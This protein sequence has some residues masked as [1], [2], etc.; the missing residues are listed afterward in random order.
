MVFLPIFDQSLLRL[1]EELPGGRGEPGY[2]GLQEGLLENTG[3][4]YYENDD[5]CGEAR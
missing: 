1:Q 2:C 4:G 5:R 3:D